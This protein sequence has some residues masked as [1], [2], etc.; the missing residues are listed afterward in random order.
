M[1]ELICKHCKK[2][3]DDEGFL[4]KMY[5]VGGNYRQYHECPEGKFVYKTLG[6]VIVVAVAAFVLW[7]IL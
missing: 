7:K 6:I 1:N 3:K 5:G 2:S 4:N